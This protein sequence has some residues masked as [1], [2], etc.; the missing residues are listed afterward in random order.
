MTDVWGRLIKAFFTFRNAKGYYSSLYGRYRDEVVSSGAT[1]DDPARL[2]SSAWY[3]H[4]VKIAELKKTGNGLY[5]LKLT[6]SGYDTLTTI[7][8]LNMIAWEAY[9]WFLG[10]AWEAPEFRLKFDGPARAGSRPIAT[11]VVHNDKTYL[12]SGGEVRV[13]FFPSRGWADVDIY[14]REILFFKDVHEP[15]IDRKLRRV[16]RL[17][18]EVSGL[19]GK[20]REVSKE[21]GGMVEKRFGDTLS[22]IDGAGLRFHGVFAEHLEEP[23]YSFIVGAL[24]GIRD[25][26]KLIYS[27]DPSVLRSNAMLV[28]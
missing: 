2:P 19:M 22:L 11:Y 21:V 5:V 1:L 13:T 27:D 4:N 23:E 18:R 26:L 24:R 16:R 14:G 6:N 17:R 8:R 7:S 10:G 25:T 3:L 9:K 20:I 15:E 12:L 28:L